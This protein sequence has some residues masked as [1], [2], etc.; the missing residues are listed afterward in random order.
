MSVEQLWSPTAGRIK[1]ISVGTN[2]YYM[3]PDPVGAIA[4]HSQASRSLLSKVNHDFILCT[5]INW[6]KDQFLE[7]DV[8]EATS[9]AVLRNRH[10]LSEFTESETGFCYALISGPSRPN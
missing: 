5:V 6:D 1:T 2:D 7:G 10:G 3:H 4:V 8:G 9:Q